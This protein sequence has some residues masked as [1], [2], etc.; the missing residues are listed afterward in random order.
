MFTFYHVKVVIHTC[1]KCILSVLL[2]SLIQTLICGLHIS[3]YSCGHVCT[4]VWSPYQSIQLWPC[5]HCCLDSI[6]VYLVVA[7]HARLSGLHISLS[8]CGHACT[9]VRTPYQS[10]QL[11]PCMHGCLDSI[12]VY[13]V[14]A[15]YARLS[16]SCKL[17]HVS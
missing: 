15:M 9:V 8:S 2:C 1:Q 3:L 17:D 11:W 13:L 6:S 4:V 7:M 12:L 5:M 16:S 10:I 14:V